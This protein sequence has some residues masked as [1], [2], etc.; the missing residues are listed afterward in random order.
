MVEYLTK[1]TV[2]VPVATHNATTVARVLMDVVVFHYGPFKELMCD[3]AAE[4]VGDVVTELVELLQARQ[5]TPVP[6]RPNLVGLVERFN[7]TW[8]DIVSMYVH[9]SQRDWDEWLGMACYAYNASRHTTTGYTPFE[10]MYGR[11]AATPDALLRDDGQDSTASP[12]MHHRQLRA[13]L[14]RLHALARLAIRRGQERQAAQYDKQR[15]ARM[16][17]R[18][19]LL[20]WFFN[21]P[22]HPGVTKLRHAWR[23]PMRIVESAGYDNFLVEEIATRRRT[24][25]HCS[26]L[27]SYVLPDRLLERIARDLEREL[28][29]ENQADALTSVDEQVSQWAQG[30]DGGPNESGRVRE[31][32]GEGSAHRGVQ[33]TRAARPASVAVPAHAGEA[34]A[35]VVRRRLRRNRIGRYVAEVEVVGANGATNW[36]GIDEFAA[37]VAQQGRAT[38]VGAHRG[39]ASRAG[40]AETGPGE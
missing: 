30:Q 20:V 16:Q 19:G 35:M 6:Y 34:V 38:V 12:A 40:A 24:V 13:R 23:G 4:F 21:P 1:W 11:E 25:A 36:I 27:Y 32:G 39:A 9:E 3:N 33:G 17:L 37:R 18:P 22:R 29:D 5:S 14:K 28:D 26:F 2:A 31:E 8:K 7:R 15:R 10:L